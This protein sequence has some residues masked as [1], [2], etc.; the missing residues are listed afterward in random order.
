MHVIVR[1]AVMSAVI[2]ALTASSCSAPSQRGSGGDSVDVAPRRDASG[3]AA[4]D[5]LSSRAKLAQLE[6]DAR[7]LARTSGCTSSSQCRT[8]P[9]GEK[10]CGGPRTYVAYCAAS[11]DS[12]ALFRK[13]AELGAAEKTHNKS[14]G[15]MSTC[16][17][18][19][20]PTVSVQG[21]SCRPDTP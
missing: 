20:P 18:R 3:A 16:E 8:A 11:T 9:V 17:F 5:T 13:L 14:S 4:N 10:A 21:G 7:A 12:I 6:A 2:A 19:L 1:T 15:M